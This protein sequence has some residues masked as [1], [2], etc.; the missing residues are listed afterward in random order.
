M[1]RKLQILL[2][3]YL[4]PDSYHRLVGFSRQSKASNQSGSYNVH[5]DIA[6]SVSRYPHA[7]RYYRSIRYEFDVSSSIYL[8]FNYG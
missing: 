8:R 7:E 2:F 5:R 1:T 3:F 4:F 6:D